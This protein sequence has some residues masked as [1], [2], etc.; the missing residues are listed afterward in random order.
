MYFEAWLK[1]E[2]EV[3]VASPQEVK[4]LGSVPLLRL[5]DSC[6]TVPA[7]CLAG[8]VLYIS[9]EVDRKAAQIHR[10]E[11]KAEQQPAISLNTK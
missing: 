4:D 3:S 9:V 1:A 7:I 2:K 5:M 10:A 11:E 8:V 6:K